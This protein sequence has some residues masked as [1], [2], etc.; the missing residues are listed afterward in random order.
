MKS[1]GNPSTLN[2]PLETENNHPILRKQV[3]A[4]V[5]SLRKRKSAGVENIPAEL[6]QAGGE[7]VITSLTTIC[8]TI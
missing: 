5:Q 1:S 2:F 4:A 7:A 8:Y 6:V 3:E